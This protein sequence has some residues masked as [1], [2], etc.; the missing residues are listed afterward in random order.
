MIIKWP[1]HLSIEQQKKYIVDLMQNPKIKV[2]ITAKVKSR[3][4]LKAVCVPA[5]SLRVLGWV[6]RMVDGRG[7]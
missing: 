5:E 4:F 3:Q 6:A 2:R 7:V 1:G